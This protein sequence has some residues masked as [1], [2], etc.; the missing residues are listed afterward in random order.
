MTAEQFQYDLA[1]W[2]KDAHD[3]AMRLFDSGCSA[4]R[5][6]E[7]R[8]AVRRL[9]RE[10]ARPRR[11]ALSGV[12]IGMP[13]A[14][15]EPMTQTGY[16]FDANRFAELLIA[17]SYP[18]KTDHESAL[19]RDYLKVHLGEFDRVEFSVRIAPAVTPDPAHLEGVQRQA[20]LNSMNRIDMVG[21]RG[22]CRCWWKRRRRSGT[23]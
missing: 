14:A 7:N 12:A 21:Y 5:L 13:I 19:L 2:F 15:T 11:Q 20:L 23:R 10:H 8:D 9:A 4:D 1:A 6:S 22:Q 17:K 18:E 3:E 16:A